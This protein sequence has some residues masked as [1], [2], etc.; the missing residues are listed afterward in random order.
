M[1]IGNLIRTEKT[2]DFYELRKRI[3]NYDHM[4]YRSDRRRIQKRKGR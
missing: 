4:T 3:Q 1:K 2:I